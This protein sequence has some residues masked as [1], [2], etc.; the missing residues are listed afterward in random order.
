MDKKFY[1]IN[2]YGC[3]MNIHDSEKL[4][5]ILQKLGYEPTED[6][7]LADVI[8]FNTCCI[9]ES[10]E[11]KIFGNIGAL[12]GIKK[13]KKDLIIAVC[14]CM[15]QQEGV[16][17]NIKQKFPFV[18]IVFG[19]HNVYMF[20]EYLKK[21]LHTHKKVYEV[22]DKER[23]I[24]EDI[25]TYR[26]SMYNGWV[27]IMYGCNNFCTYCIVPYVRGRERSRKMSDILKEVQDLVS[28]GYKTITLLGQN[29]N[30]YGNDINDSS[31]NFANL[32]SEICKIEGDFRVRFMTSHPK[33]LTQEVIDVIAREPKLSKTIHL[34][35]QSGSNSILHAMNRR[36][37]V[38]HYKGLIDR[39]KEAIPTVSLTTDLIV[40]FPGE[41]EQ[42]FED[43][44][45]LVR[46]CK[47]TGIFGF[48]YSKRSGTIAEKMDNQVPIA[49]KRE[50]VNKLLALSKEI[51]K[52]ITE[53]MVNTTVEVLMYNEKNKFVG[54][55]ECGKTVEIVN[56]T[57]NTKAGEFYNVVIDSYKANKLFGR[58]I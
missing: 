44:L 25:P 34:P 6:D 54:K 8:V 21:H 16:A 31:I 50:R 36:Y 17:D 42:D 19:T 15:S 51:G 4:A 40:G 3:Q 35:V 30:S 43:T 23:E 57:E 33:D 53:A 52:Q 5:G 13:A 27:N 10:A 58:I 37:T 47:Y 12:K 24:V 39:I 1:K 29:V 2:T 45:D 41:T 48:M 14:G 7:Y 20:E 18:N 46:Y 11:Q 32:L 49:V 55:T 22:W 38:E 9:R 26:T 28:Q 56:P